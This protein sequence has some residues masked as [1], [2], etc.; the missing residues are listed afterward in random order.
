ML[1]WRVIKDNYTDYALNK[2]F[3]NKDNLLAEEYCIFLESVDDVPAFV[4]GASKIEA[5]IKERK[6]N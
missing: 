1:E 4:I 5:A 3:H 2:I 6:K